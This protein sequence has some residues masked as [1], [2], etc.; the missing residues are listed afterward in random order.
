M[1]F[2][3]AGDLPVAPTRF[4]RLRDRCEFVCPMRELQ[5]TKKQAIPQSH[6][7]ANEQVLDPA[8]E[9]KSYRPQGGGLRLDGLNQRVGLSH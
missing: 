1:V 3:T 6:L 5:D 4:I 7:K 9:P 8:R 2:S